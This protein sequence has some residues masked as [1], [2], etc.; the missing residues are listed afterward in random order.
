MIA[1]PIQIYHS[2]I[3]DYHVIRVRISLACPVPLCLRNRDILPYI[4][5]SVILGRYIG[6]YDFGYT[7]DSSV[8]RAFKKARRNLQ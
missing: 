5:E 7:W 8:E 3:G 2:M 4:D 1:M 6:R